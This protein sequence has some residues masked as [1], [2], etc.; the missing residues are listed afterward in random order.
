MSEASARWMDLGTRV[1]SALVMA[2]VT[3][4]ALWVSPVT[5]AI[6]A[7]LIYCVMLW[8]L[9][10]LCDPPVSGRVRI[11]L[12]VIPVISI[13]IFHW[14]GSYFGYL[15]G[16][17]ALAVPLVVGTVILRQRRLLWLGYGTLLAIAALFLIYANARYGPVGVLLLIGVV[18]ISDTAGYFAGRLIGGPKFWPAISPKKTWSGTVAG[19]VFT[20]VFGYLVFPFIDI[21]PLKGAVLAVVL[22]FSAQMGDIA[23]S[24]MKRRAGIKDSSNLLPGHGGVLDRLDGLVSAACLA[25]AIALVAGA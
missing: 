2:A 25:G 7:L 17:A 1:L 14:A 16:F 13:V 4:A 21:E 10:P 20:G 8:E 22:G 24:A 15:T 18:A 11:G 3:V 23:E 9:S 6:Y 5:W 19:W 12:A